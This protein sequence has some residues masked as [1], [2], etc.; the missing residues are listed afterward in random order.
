M[1]IVIIK[2]SEKETTEYYAIFKQ[3]HVCL[4]ITFI[5]INYV[6]CCN[7]THKYLHT[8]GHNSAALV[9]LLNPLL[10]PQDIPQILEWRFFQVIGVESLFPCERT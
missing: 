7:Y 9:S 6:I 1:H 5:C 10:N 4:V 3:C 8:A 2:K